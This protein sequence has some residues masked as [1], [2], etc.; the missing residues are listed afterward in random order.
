LKGL[1]AETLVKT[2]ASLLAQRPSKINAQVSMPTEVARDST[3][4]DEGAQRRAGDG[5]EQSGAP[6]GSN[7]RGGGASGVV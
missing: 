6:S 2:A 3:I 4:A 5:G 1:L 7:G